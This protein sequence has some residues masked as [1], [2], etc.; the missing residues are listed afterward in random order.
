MVLCPLIM[1]DMNNKISLDPYLYLQRSE[2]ITMH[3]SSLKQRDLWSELG[4][5]TC[6]QRGIK[7]EIKSTYHYH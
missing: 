2:M 7:E 4:H 6:E 5:G 1:R 3:L